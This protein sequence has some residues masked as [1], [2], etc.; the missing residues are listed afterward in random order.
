MQSERDP[1]KYRLRLPKSFPRGA[2]R[3]HNVPPRKI[4]R[5]VRI[6][7]INPDVKRYSSPFC[8]CA[9]AQ[10]VRPASECVG[11]ARKGPSFGPSCPRGDFTVDVWSMFGRCPVEIRQRFCRDYKM[12]CKQSGLSHFYLLDFFKHLRTSADYGQRRIR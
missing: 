6:S 11:A 10:T 5:C 3:D 1:H 4:Y 12:A 9:S 8:C 7:N 2:S